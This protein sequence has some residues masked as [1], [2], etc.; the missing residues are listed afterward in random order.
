MT[1]FKYK[2]SGTCTE[3]QAR[4]VVDF[5]NEKETMIRRIRIEPK[6]LPAFFSSPDFYK[7]IKE[8][9]Y[10]DDPKE[11]NLQKYLESINQLK[12]ESEKS[13]IMPLT[14]IIWN[15]QLKT[16]N[17][18]LYCLDNEKIFQI[19]SELTNPSKLLSGWKVRMLYGE[20]LEQGSIIKTKEM[21]STLPDAY[22]LSMLN[23]LLH[24]WIRTADHYCDYLECEADLW[25]GG[26]KI[27]IESEKELIKLKKRLG[28]FGLSLEESTNNP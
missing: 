13:K 23:V 18:L 17:S 21:V 22:Y 2:I 8:D 1:D 6:N 9:F 25:I 10:G 28:S 14:K 15:G 5:L 4:K 11:K 7:L 12:I 16:E 27:T 26:G 3:E 24:P 20:D 19:Y